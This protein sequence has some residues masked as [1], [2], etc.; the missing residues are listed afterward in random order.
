MSGLPQG[1]F[2]RRGPSGRRKVL[3]VSGVLFVLLLAWSYAILSYG[4]G[5]ESGGSAPPEARTVPSGN[6][7]SEAT[8]SA[9]GTGREAVPDD[10]AYVEDGIGGQPDGDGA[11]G[12]RPEQDPAAGAA[13]P[14]RTGAEDGSS[15][16]EDY[17]PDPLG[18]GAA[19]DLAP[20]DEERVRFAA[21]RFVTAAYGYSGDDEDAYNQGV[22]ATVAW[23]AFYQSPGSE[24]IERYAARVGEGG[25]RS[26]ALLSRFEFTKSG[27]AMASGYA[28]FETG[29]GYGPDG[30]LTG[31]KLSYR[32]KMT[33][34]RSGGAWVV[35]HTDEIEET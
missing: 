25:T 9:P 21:A 18:T 33:L 5:G 2:R 30:G 17:R 8:G 24:E 34:V 29:E 10:T 16:P 11:G 20:T 6:G 19:G 1:G 31:R 27:G 13:D 14:S 12:A 3:V 15:E 28:Y 4:G 23:P 35:K 7:A 32:Q 22:G 26:A